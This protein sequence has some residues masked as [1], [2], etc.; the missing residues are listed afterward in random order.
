MEEVR[1]RNQAPKTREDVGVTVKNTHCNPV[2]FRCR[3]N[4]GNFGASIFYL[5]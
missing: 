4:F 3:L 1:D 2:L 5:K